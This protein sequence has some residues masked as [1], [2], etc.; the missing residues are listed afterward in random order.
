MSS[1]EVDV[2]TTTGSNG[3]ISR[4]GVTC[5]AGAT[6]RVGRAEKTLW[7]MRGGAKD[8]MGDVGT[9]AGRE[10]DEGSG[11]RVESIPTGGWSPS[12]WRRA[13]ESRECCVER[14]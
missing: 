8:G 11:R 3:M 1:L 7:L 5:W 9:S 10:R 14:C 6:L 13:V 4:C 2:G 12:I